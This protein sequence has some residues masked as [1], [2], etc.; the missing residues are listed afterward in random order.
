MRFLTRSLLGLFLL[1][2]TI[3]L[4][5]VAWVTLKS[6]IDIRNAEGGASRPA[7]ERVFTARVMTLQPVRIAPEMTAFGEV[8]SRRQLELRAAAAGRIVELAPEFADGTAVE[9]GQLLIR[10]DPADAQSALDLARTDMR[11][12]EAEAR[13]AARA[14]ELARDDLAAAEAQEALRAQALERQ[15]GIAGRGLGVA[16]DL[17]AAELAMSN[18][19]QATLSRRQ[20]LAEAEARVNRAA[21]ARERVTLNLADAE[22]RLAETEL[23]AGFSGV[24]SGV[25]AVAGGLVAMNEK[26]GDLIDPEALEVSFRLSNAQFARLID[27]DGALLPQPVTAALDVFGDELVAEGNLARVD[28][29]VG[30]GLSGRLIFANLGQA[31][32]FRPGDF[33]TLTIIEPAL[34]GVALLPAQAVGADGTLLALGP[35]ERLEA[36][37]VAVL[38]RQGDDVI[39]RVGAL[40][41]RE[42]VVERTTLLGA[43]IRVRPIRGDQAAIRGGSGEEDLVD[44]TPERRAALIAFVEE[45]GAMGDDAKASVIARLRDDRVPAEM[46]ARIEARMGG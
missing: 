44:L 25:A 5:A 22:R 9:A 17:E 11:E 26:L 24:L 31:R 28:A 32:G 29:A 38:R 27:G 15:R 37:P 8:R 39:V 1:A 40:A 20:A 12:A 33:V 21:T 19:V 16:A 18:A 23:R 14:L 43:G 10:I 42:I 36:V 3:A 34:D 2:V 30:E 35:D 6:A 7:E 46:V 45:S 13:D 4:L 41:G